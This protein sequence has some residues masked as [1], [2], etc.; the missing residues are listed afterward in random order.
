[1]I[2]VLFVTAALVVL[3]TLA[4]DEATDEADTV[5]EKVKQKVEYVRKNPKAYIGAVTDKTEDTIQIKSDS[6]EILQVSVNEETSFVKLGKVPT[7]VKFTD[8]AIG[9][10]IVAMGFRDTSGVLS[11]KRIL[12]T[13]P[14]TFAPR[15]IA[16][17]EVTSVKKGAISLQDK[18]K[19]EELL[20]EPAKNNLVTLA[21]DN[22][23][24][25]INFSEIHQGDRIIAVGT[26][27]EET[28]T[29]RRIHVVS[30]APSP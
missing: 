4:Q 30:Q 15:Q 12:L 23:V 1:M 9:D 2:A 10:F 18:L 21:A 8:L 24:A 27:Q 5:R 19:G 29:A 17:G 7:R 25:K 11:G 13:S 14:A 26:R 16:M 3:P 28:F 22:K 20:I 6:G